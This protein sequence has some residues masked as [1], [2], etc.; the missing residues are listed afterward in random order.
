M[1]QVAGDGYIKGTAAAVGGLDELI[2]WLVSVTPP[3]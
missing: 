3:P 1:L 2:S